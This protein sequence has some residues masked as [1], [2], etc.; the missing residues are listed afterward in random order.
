MLTIKFNG[1]TT[2]NVE[3]KK[4]PCVKHWKQPILQRC[5]QYL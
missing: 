1:F 4:Q 5:I 2:E 3:E